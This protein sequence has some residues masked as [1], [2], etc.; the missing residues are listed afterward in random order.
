MTTAEKLSKVYEGVEKTEALNA[1]LEQALYGT[2]EGVKSFYDE[3]WDAFQKNGT[4]TDYRYAFFVN[5]DDNTYNPKYDIVCVGMA[6]SAFG[7]CK[8]TDT[9]RAIDI[10]GATDTNGFFSDADKLV[11]IRKLIVSEATPIATNFM[12]WMPLLE[13][14]EIEGTIG[15]SFGAKYST[16]L[17]KASITSIINALSTT[18]E[19]LTVTL[20][21]AA[22]N[23][24]FETSEGANDGEFSAEWNELEKSREDWTISLV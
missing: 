19:G 24:A 20:S 15:C 12:G 23:K 14:L 1:E 2:S 21:K 22:V 9:K 4:R 7:A 13:N 11:T 3:F 8:I 10:T 18:T 16:K 6:N 5:W 17:S